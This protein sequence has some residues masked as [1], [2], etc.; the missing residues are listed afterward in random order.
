MP[1]LSSQGFVPG[2]LLTAV[3]AVTPGVAQVLPAGTTGQFARVNGDPGMLPTHDVPGWPGGSVIELVPLDPLATARIEANGGDRFVASGFAAT[4]GNDALARAAPGRLGGH[5]GLVYSHGQDFFSASVTVATAAVFT[6]S[7]PGRPLEIV[8]VDLGAGIV[9]GIGLFGPDID[10]SAE[11]TLFFSAN[12]G[13]VASRLLFQDRAFNA[14]DVDGE[15]SITLPNPF[16]PAKSVTFDYYDPSDITYDYGTR[17]APFAV[18]VQLDASGQGQLWVA[19]ELTL[20]IGEGGDSPPSLTF[21]GAIDYADTV[22]GFVR[23]GDSDLAVSGPG[24]WLV[25]AAGA[26]P[27]PSSILPVTPPVPEPGAWALMLAGLAAVGTIARRR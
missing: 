6:L 16:N 12:G 18:D 26:A 15:R 22:T 25:L 10:A 19:L 14:R 11:G 3:V 21:G 9:G 20:H 4:V 23:A 2:L 17:A 27:P 8:S 1:R 13:A 7:D 5:V 24:G